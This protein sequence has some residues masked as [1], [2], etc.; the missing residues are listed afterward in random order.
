MSDEPRF[1]IVSPFG[2][3]Q[4]KLDEV[5]G[6]QGVKVHVRPDLCPDGKTGYLI[7]NSFIRPRTLL[8]EITDDLV[9]SLRN[10]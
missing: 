6:G 4:E 8:E 2:L 10:G 7:D 9:R 5:A 1:V 3:S